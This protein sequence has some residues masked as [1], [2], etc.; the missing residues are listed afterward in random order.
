MVLRSKEIKKLFLFLFIF[1]I[2][3]NTKNGDFMKK[4]LT[5]IIIFII[6]LSL[7]EEKVK[8]VFSEELN[9]DLY[10]TYYIE[11]DNLNSNNFN[12]YFKNFDIVALIPDINPIYKDKINIIYFYKDIDDFK[13]NYIKRLKEKDYYI[14][15]NKYMIKPIKINRVITY[16]SINDIYDSIS[17]NN[18]NYTIVKSDSY[19]KISN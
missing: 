13:K 5:T 9:N 14:E 11:M 15:A 16:S 7:K 12:D 1:S 17:L 4:I 8:T 3:M 19:V 2:V 10:M 18:K 6:Y